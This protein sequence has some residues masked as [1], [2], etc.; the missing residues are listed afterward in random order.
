MAA[1]KAT[2]RDEINPSRANIAHRTPKDDEIDA[3]R[4]QIAK[5][6]ANQKRRE[7]TNALIANF[8][9]NSAKCEL[10]HADHFTDECHLLQESP[11]EVNYVG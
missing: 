7:S 8:T 11:E 3:L 5:L 10:C 9:S 2:W 4:D 6:T 1:G